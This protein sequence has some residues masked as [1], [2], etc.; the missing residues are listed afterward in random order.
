MNNVAGKMKI[1]T[2]LSMM[3]LK[4]QSGNFLTFLKRKGVHIN[5]SHLCMVNT[6]TLQWIGQAHPSLLCRNGIKERIKKMMKSE[7]NTMQ[8]ALFPWAFN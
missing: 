2:S 1:F 4:N 8:Y 5:Y 7:Y 3:Q 6:V